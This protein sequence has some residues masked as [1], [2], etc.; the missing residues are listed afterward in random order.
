MYWE[1]REVARQCATRW[2]TAQLSKR[3]ARSLPT[4]WLGKVAY[5]RACRAEKKKRGGRRGRRICLG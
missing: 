4:L 2:S 5:L 3:Y 1:E